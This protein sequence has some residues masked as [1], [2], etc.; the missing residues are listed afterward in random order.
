MNRLSSTSRK[1]SFGEDLC[2]RVAVAI[3]VG[4]AK[5]LRSWNP[6]PF[7]LRG[8]R[9]DLV[10]HPVGA[11]CRELLVTAAVIFDQMALLVCRF[12]LVRIAL[13]LAADDK[14]R[15]LDRVLGEYG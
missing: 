8:N 5:I 10:H 4:R 3:A 9:V 2:Q 14:E 6:E 13:D 11:Q 15:R 12:D 7:N 1:V